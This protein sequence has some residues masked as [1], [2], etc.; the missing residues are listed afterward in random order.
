[1][2]KKEYN[3][4]YRQEH[5]QKMKESNR[6]YYQENKQKRKGRDKK[7]YQEH[8]Q[9][10]NEYTRKY[11]QENKQELKEHEKK[12]RQKHIQEIGERTKKYRT[13]KRRKVLMHYS[14]GT[15]K[16]ANCGYNI[17]EG[18]IID[19][20]NGGGNK[21]RRENPRM[22][23]HLTAWLFKNNYPKG[24]QVLCWNCNFL[25]SAYPKIYKAVSKN[26]T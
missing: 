24:F 19:H 7:Y 15:M 21:Q 18:L 10:I 3:K 8:K 20:I 9:K 14:N 16:C 13:G 4:K 2:N 11:Y 1:M 12:Y 22:G 6:K 5:K 25:K 23:K 26:K 17:F